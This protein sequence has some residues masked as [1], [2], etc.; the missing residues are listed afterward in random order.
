MSSRYVRQM[1][2]RATL[3]LPAV[4]AAHEQ[5]PSDRPIEP[6]AAIVD[7]FRSHAVVA[8]AED[9]GNEQGH[10]FRLALLR[11]PRF[12]EARADILVEFG[13]A[14]YQA[15]VDR[16][17][18]G[19]TVP[20]DELRRVWQDT[21]QISGV[22]DRPIYEEFFRVVREVN[23]AL[24]K[25]RRVRLLLGDPPVDWDAA[26]RAPRV[27]GERRMFGQ[28]VPDDAAAARL[29]RDRHAAE[30]ARQALAKG[31]R[32][33]VVFGGMHLTRRPRSVVG[34]LESDAAVRVFTVTNATA[35]TYDSLVATR[36]DA[37]SWPVPSFWNVA[38]T[39][40]SRELGGFDAVLYLG[41][42]SAMTTSQLP[43][44]RCGDPR[45]L[46]MRRERLALALAGA[47]P[48]QIGQ[49]L[50]RDCPGTAVR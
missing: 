49:L 8:L 26:V 39:D 33:L 35:R 9:H 18:N 21:T 48:A 37:T 11:D 47:P 7:A 32:V 38:G 25:D 22:W 41:P 20:D 36:P 46:A 24:P 19:E 50:A 4:L 12:A 28:P 40:A 1:F 17:V 6:I 14:R 2:L 44:A 15:L 42:P 29:D 3:A 34:H 30:V 31:R 23:A 13:N 16:F 5:A 43:A 45:Y 27:P 10:R